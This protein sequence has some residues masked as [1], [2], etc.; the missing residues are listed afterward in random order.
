MQIGEELSSVQITLDVPS[1]AEL[2]V[3]KSD[4]SLTQEDVRYK[5]HVVRQIDLTPI[6]DAMRANSS[7]ERARR[8]LG[9][10]AFSK[11]QDLSQKRESAPKPVFNLSLGV[12]G[13]TVKPS[14]YENG[15]VRQDERGSFSP[16]G[17]CH[18]SD[19]ERRPVDLLARIA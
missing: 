4:P 5:D 10:A 17:K 16:S 18:N 8:F 15:T 12:L 2:S 19:A 3:R 13:G 11:Q 1:N 9:P 7:E 6:A 14:S